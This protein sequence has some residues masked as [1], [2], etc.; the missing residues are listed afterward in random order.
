MKAADAHSIHNLTISLIE[1][2]MSG[3][4]DEI[5]PLMKTYEHASRIMKTS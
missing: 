4:V 1:A 2:I 3:A 5:A